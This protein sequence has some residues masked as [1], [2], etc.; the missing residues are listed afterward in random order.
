MTKSFQIE[1][2]YMSKEEKEEM[3]ALHFQEKIMAPV[4]IIF[5]DLYIQLIFM[6]LG[7]P[8]GGCGGDGG[9]VYFRCSGRLSSLYDLRRA[10]FKGNSGKPGKVK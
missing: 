8:D 3:D 2:G 9:A 10:H 1:R 4:C 5:H 7:V 6:Y